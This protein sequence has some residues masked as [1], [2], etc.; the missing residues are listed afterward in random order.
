MSSANDPF[1][2]SRLRL[3]CDVNS[4]DKPQLVCVVLCMTVMHNGTLV[5]VNW[6][7]RSI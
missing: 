4:Q 5:N 7:V 1:H 6:H 2:S 3:S